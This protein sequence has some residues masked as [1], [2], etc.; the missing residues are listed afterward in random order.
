MKHSDPI[1]L[2]KQALGASLSGCYFKKGGAKRGGPELVIVC[3]PSKYAARLV[4]VT[5]PRVSDVLGRLAVAILERASWCAPDGLSPFIAVL[6]PAFGPKMVEAVRDFIEQHAGDV[7]WMLV[8][9]QGGHHL[10]MKRKTGVIVTDHAAETPSQPQRPS[11]RR[12][13]LFS[14]LYR[15]MLKLL[16]LRDAPAPYE[17]PFRGKV[18]NPTH[19]GRAAQVSVETAHQF[20]RAFAERDFLRVE[21]GDLKLV[22]RKELLEALLTE[23]RQASP[24]WTHARPADGGTFDLDHMLAS[25]PAGGIAVGGFEACRRYGLLHTA[26]GVP[27]LLL[28]GPPNALVA[29]W[30]LDYCG[31]REAQ[32]VIAEPRYRASVFRAVTH[33]GG[34]RVVD[35]L[36]AALDVVPVP[37]RGFEQAE[38]VVAEILSWGGA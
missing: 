17:A 5:A 26:P 20:V 14:D 15:W 32:I 18:A 7:S 36:Q 27:L 34:V 12:G 33:V 24:V 1:E 11:N 28:E 22:R 25:R 30:D 13:S 16:L 19:L 21:R 10:E 2:V 29:A 23:E 3:P 4:A 6:M 37:G 35:L 9:P 8:N 31:P 38:L